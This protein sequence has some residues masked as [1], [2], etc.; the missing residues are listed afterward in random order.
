MKT[1]LC[2]TLYRYVKSLVDKLDA[3]IESWREVTEWLEEAGYK[4]QTPPEIPVDSLLTEKSVVNVVRV[5]RSVTTST[6][7]SEPCVRLSPHTAP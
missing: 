1:D 3:R 4:R 7:P 2:V 5:D 6:S